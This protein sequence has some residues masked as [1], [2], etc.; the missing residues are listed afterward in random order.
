MRIFRLEILQEMCVVSNQ[1]ERRAQKSFVGCNKG[2]FNYFSSN[3]YEM[4][5]KSPFDDNSLYVY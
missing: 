4:V 2:G 5:Y 3:C 1:A